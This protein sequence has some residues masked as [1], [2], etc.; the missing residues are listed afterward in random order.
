MTILTTLFL[1][2]GI[3]AGIVFAVLFTLWYLENKD[4]KWK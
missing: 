4:R 3:G 2:L 1:G